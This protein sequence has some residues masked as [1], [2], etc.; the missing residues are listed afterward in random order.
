MDKSQR[1]ARQGALMLPFCYQPKSL[2]D[3]RPVV[4]KTWIALRPSKKH[5]PGQMLAEYGRLPSGCHKN[6]RRRHS[7]SVR[8]SVIDSPVTHRNE[9][10]ANRSTKAQVLFC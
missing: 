5:L 6:S 3:P 10:R 4:L 7:M 2:H 8:V 9:V 1:R